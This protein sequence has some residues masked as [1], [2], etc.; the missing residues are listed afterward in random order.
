MF[1]KHYIVSKSDLVTT[2]LFTILNDDDNV[3][4]KIYLH[5]H[6]ERERCI[7]LLKFDHM[8]STGRTRN[9]DSSKAFSVHRKKRGP[10]KGISTESMNLSQQYG[11]LPVGTI[12][13]MISVVLSCIL[14]SSI[15]SSNSILRVPSGFLTKQYHRNHHPHQILICALKPCVFFSSP[16]WMDD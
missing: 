2:N 13:T 1:E 7:E 16:S 5:T 6:R 12:W 9:P 14:S 11:S 10:R 4:I 3:H 8:R 15:L